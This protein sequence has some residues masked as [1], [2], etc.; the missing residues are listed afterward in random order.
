MSNNQEDND[1]YEIIDL[2]GDD[3]NVNHY[4]VSTGGDRVYD[5]DNEVEYRYRRRRPREVIDLTGDDDYEQERPSG[6]NRV[7]I[8]DPIH[9]IAESIPM[10]E[11]DFRG[12]TAAPNDDDEVVYLGRRNYGVIPKKGKKRPKRPDPQLQMWTTHTDPNARWSVQRSESSGVPVNHQYASNG[13]LRYHSPYVSWPTPEAQRLQRAKYHTIASINELRRMRNYQMNRLRRSS[14][15][16][17][18]IQRAR[19]RQAI[20]KISLAISRRMS[21]LDDLKRQW[22]RLRFQH[23]RIYAYHPEH[24]P[25]YSYRF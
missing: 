14:E 8:D 10:E 17:E 6:G 23:Q 22:W 13:R 3:D 9:G 7:I 19:I 18:G 1:G 12:A 25:D 5:V 2:T 24:E 4:R 20:N 21:R 16:I 11:D 15:P